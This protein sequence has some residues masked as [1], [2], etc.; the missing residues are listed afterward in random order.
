MLTLNFILQAV[1]L[2]K[3]HRHWRYFTG[4]IKIYW[5]NF[6]PLV[7]HIHQRVENFVIFFHGS[8]IP[9]QRGT[10][11]RTDGELLNR[12]LLHLRMGRLTS[13]FKTEQKGG[14]MAVFGRVPSM[15]SLYAKWPLTRDVRLTVWCPRPSAVLV[16][17]IHGPSFQP[18]QTSRAK[19]ESVFNQTAGAKHSEDLF[20]SSF[21]LWMRRDSPYDV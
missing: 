13:S 19:R 9:I 21:V 15:R 11:G 8:K 10:D 5:C 6:P 17:D 14:L 2:L 7:N 16:L 4:L 18:G 3:T 20:S 1:F 12:C